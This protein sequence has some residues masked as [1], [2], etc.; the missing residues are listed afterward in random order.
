MEFNT[1]P[2]KHQVSFSSMVLRSNLM[3]LNRNAKSPLSKIIEGNPKLFRMKNY[4]KKYNINEDFDINDDK[5]TSN[6]TATGINNESS[7]ISYN[8]KKSNLNSFENIKSI[9]LNQHLIIENINTDNNFYPN[10][11]GTKK[12]K[13]V[14]LSIYINPNNKAITTTNINEEN[15]SNNKE[16]KKRCRH[17]QVKREIYMSN[18]IQENKLGYNKNINVERNSNNKIIDTQTKEKEYKNKS[19]TIPINKRIKDNFFN[20]SKKNKSFLEYYLSKNKLN[21][22]TI[23]NNLLENYKENKENI[24]INDNKNIYFFKRNTFNC[25]VK[26]IKSPNKN[27]NN[28]K[29]NSISKYRGIG[30][31]F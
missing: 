26:R 28:K 7:K 24:E 30:K 12:K 25:K 3:N 1:K 15:N 27:M 6:L 29:I 16:I 14:S 5:S 13:K 19:I 4:S 8:V 18:N 11:I 31:F 23:K 21:K 20:N 10:F 2:K 17:K 22:K 9:D